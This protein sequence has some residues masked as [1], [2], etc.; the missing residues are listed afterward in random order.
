M[1]F[2]T[3]MPNGQGTSCLAYHQVGVV[4]PSLSNGVKSAF[5][6]LQFKAGNSKNIA[7]CVK[8]YIAPPYAHS[9]VCRQ[10]ASVFQAVCGILTHGWLSDDEFFRGILL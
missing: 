2:V 6:V 8:S 1:H 10:I 3:A 7:I 5:N 9:S 4:F